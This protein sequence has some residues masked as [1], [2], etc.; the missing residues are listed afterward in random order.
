MALVV[1]LL[2][3]GH[4]PVRCSQHV[5]QREPDA[6]VVPHRERV[7]LVDRYLRSRNNALVGIVEHKRRECLPGSRVVQEIVSLGVLHDTHA[8]QLA[9]PASSGEILSAV[10]QILLGQRVPMDLVVRVRR[11]TGHWKTFVV[12]TPVDSVRRIRQAGCGVG[13]TPVR[14]EGELVFFFRAVRQARINHDGRP[15]DASFEQIHA[16]LAVEDRHRRFE[17]DEITLAISGHQRFGPVVA[18]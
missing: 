11:P 15:A 10:Q 5:G 8:P 9:D 12:E 2:A 3:H 4:R 7:N 18:V 13:A 17:V 6:L 16:F 1:I 14:I